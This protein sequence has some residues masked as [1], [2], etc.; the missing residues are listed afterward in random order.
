MSATTFAGSAQFAAVSVLSAAGG[1]GAAAVAAILLN[2]RYAPIGISVASVIRGRTLRRLLEAQLVVDESWA[3]SR[4]RDG[5][6]TEAPHRRGLR[7]LLLLGRRDRAGGL[8][9][10]G[11][12][13]SPSLGLDG[14]F[15]ALFLAL[16]VPQ[17]HSR[18]ALVAAPSAERSHSSSS[19]SP[20]RSADRRR[21]RRLPRR[22]EEELSSTWLIVAIVGAGDRRLERPRPGLAR[23]ARA[24]GGARRSC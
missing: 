8:R 13:E 4:S 5:S 21:H 16:L 10:Q 19:R 3:L 11:A 20:P 7:P 15:A 2:A 12:R 17:I 1:V 23:G 18:R 9:R 22:L 14:A 24:A 6:S